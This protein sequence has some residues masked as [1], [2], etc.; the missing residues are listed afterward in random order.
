[1]ATPQQHA[2]VLSQGRQVFLAWVQ[3]DRP[4][5]T[6]LYFQQSDDAGLSWHAP[7]AIAHGT[8]VADHPFLLSS[9][10]AVFASWFTSVDGYRLMSVIGNK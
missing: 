7:R 10:G 9:N 5:G 1:M 3:P 4:A 8:G 6:A 2:V